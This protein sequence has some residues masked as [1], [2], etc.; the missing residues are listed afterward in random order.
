MEKLKP[1]RIL[2]IIY[3]WPPP[4]HGLA[5]GPYFLSREQ[6][7][8][9][10]KLTVFTGGLDIKRRLLK[11]VVKE[12]PEENVVVYHMLRALSQHIGP[13]LTSSPMAFFGYLWKK[14]IRRN[15]DLVHGHGHNTLWLNLYKLVFGRIDKTPYVLHYHMCSKERVAQAVK[16]GEKFSFLQ[17][18]WEIP[19]TQL[20][21]KLGIRVAN[22]CVFPSAS[23]KE[24]C[25]KWYK[26]KSNNLYVVENG[27]PDHIFSPAKKGTTKEKELL[28]I[29][30]LSPR[31]GVD[32]IIKS[33]KFLSPEYKFRWIGNIQDESY[34]EEIKKL[35][36]SLNLENRVILQGYVSNL[37]VATY[38]QKAALFVLASHSEGLPKVVIE[39]LACGTPVLASGFKAEEEIDGLSYFSKLD[40]KTIAVEI[41]S[42]L[43]NKSHVDVEKIQKV[44]SWHA[45][46][47]EIDKIYKT[48]LS[49]I[50]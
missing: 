41:M 15:V 40:E 36:K 45:K 13:F 43:E 25:I 29:G 31:K 34:L 20:S 17:K 33:L 21:E 16:A 22:A 6:G 30:V 5:P 37:E 42:T 10:H 12:T 27:Y 39:S 47:L 4:W 28:N 24:E 18:Y 49:R 19:L 26:P 35:V 2:R 48:L 32:L 44:Y 11:G 1:L 8:L 14:Y 7:L 9:G 46:A 38:Y 23:T 3:D 50:N